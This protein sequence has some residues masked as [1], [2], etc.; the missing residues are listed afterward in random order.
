[1]TNETTE[2]VKECEPTRVYNIGETVKFMLDNY[3]T[4]YRYNENE[5]VYFREGY[6]MVECEITN[7]ADIKL[8][9]DYPVRNIYDEQE[10]A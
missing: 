7:I 10:N 8:V 9:L 4:L 5:G 6:K 2:C 1:M 3:G